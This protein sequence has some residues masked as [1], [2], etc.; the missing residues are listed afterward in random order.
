MSSILEDLQIEA[1]NQNSPVSDLLRKAKIVAVKLGRADFES[2]I[3]KELGG[4]DAKSDRE[5]P[6]YRVVKGELKAWNPY[7]GWQLVH[8]D[9]VE[10]ANILS[11]RGIVQPIGE[12]DDLIK[13]STDGGP[14]HIGY[15]AEAQKMITDAIGFKTDV[16]F[17]IGRNAAMG[18]LEGARNL[19]LDWALKLDKAGVR[20]EGFSFSKADQ[21]KAQENVVYRIEHIQNFSGTLG[22]IS[23]RPS[24]VIN[25]Y[26][27]PKKET[28]QL[29]AQIERYLPEVIVEPEKI[30]EV[31]RITG[32]LKA[33]IINEAPQKSKVNELLLSLRSIFEGVAGNV[34][35]EGIV[36]GLTKI[37]A[38][39]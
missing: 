37:L 26:N 17:M 31:K 20:G 34:I 33:E 21:E 7:H 12:L 35:A 2:W 30:E 8:F 6:P 27:F 3:D 29:I 32:S 15:S 10:T 36:V 25:Q 38:G 39:G 11:E 24:L 23:G 22:E 18:V 16:K 4:Y 1:T 5:L 28:E 19:I 9:D 13:D 14:F